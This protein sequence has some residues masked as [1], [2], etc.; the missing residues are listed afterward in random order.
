VTKEPDTLFTKP[1]PKEEIVVEP[2]TVKAVIVVVAKVEVPVTLRVPEKEGLLATA[3]VLV[4]DR[5]ILLPALK[6]V[7]GLL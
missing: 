7:I 3:I 1:V 5:D 6:K 2:E 4:P